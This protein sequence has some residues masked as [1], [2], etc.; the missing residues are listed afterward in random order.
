MRILIVGAGLSGSVIARELAEDGH[1]VE[2][3]DQ[4]DHVAGN[5]YDYVN[6]HGIRVH[7]Y[8]PHLFHTSNEEVWNYLSH[9]TNWLPYKHKVKALLDDGRKRSRCILS[10]LYKKDVGCIT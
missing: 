1:A 4:R 2:V 9:F 10:S 5:A 6:R 8:G 7:K 3:I